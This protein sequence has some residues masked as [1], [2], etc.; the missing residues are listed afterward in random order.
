MN[1]KEFEGNKTPVVYKITNLKNGKFYIGSSK[2][3][4]KR[5][6]EHI[7]DLHKQEH[8]SRYFQRAWNKYGET[9]F[10]FEILEV[11]IE[12]NKL[13]EREQHY[14]DTLL[15]AQEYIKKENKKFRKLGYNITP[16][17]GSTLG[18]KMSKETK[19]KLSLIRKG[20]KQT[21]E[22]VENRAASRRG[23]KL[24]Q[25]TKDKMSKTRIERKIPSARK[26]VKLSEETKVRMSSSHI[27]KRKTAAQIEAQIKR[28]TGKKIIALGKYK[29]VVELTE[30]FEFKKVYESVK[31][32]KL[33]GFEPRRV[34]DVIYLKKDNHK[35][36]IFVSYKE[37]INLMGNGYYN[38]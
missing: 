9:S 28:Q 5:F 1:V 33:F 20:K 17:A 36:S 30:N 25:E 8:H 26:G 6:K 10:Y 2:N 16:T 3:L 24:S 4:I 13:I 19:L 27:G 38:K 14:L 15:F 34:C 22:H 12:E 23:S 31:E 35:G 29:K 37:Y 7:T 32:T 11:V 18:V 21:P